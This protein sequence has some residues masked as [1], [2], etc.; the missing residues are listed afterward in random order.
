MSAG[1]PPRPWPPRWPPSSPQC[2]RRGACGVSWRRPR[3]REHPLRV[4]SVRRRRAWSLLRRGIGGR[5]PGVA[6]DRPGRA[7]ALGSALGSLV[8]AAAHE[9]ARGE[10]R[11]E[12]VGVALLVEGLVEQTLRVAVVELPR[13]RARGAVGRDLVVL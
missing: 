1:P 4:R 8:D 10:L 6:G 13:E 3:A 2:P 5:S 9:A 12:L 7:S 11:E